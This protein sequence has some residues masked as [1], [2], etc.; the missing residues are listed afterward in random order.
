MTAWFKHRHPQ[1]LPMSTV[2]PALAND[3]SPARFAPPPW[4]DD[5]P[6]WREIDTRLE[7][8]H[9]ARRIDHAVARLDLADL[10]AAYAGTGSSAYRPELLLRVVLYEMRRGHGSP[11]TWYEDA[12]LYDPVR[13]LLRGSTPS[14]TCWYAFRDRLGPVL[15]ALQRQPLAAALAEGLTPATRGALDGTVVAANASRH[16]VL[17]A[18]KLQERLQQLDTVRAADESSASAVLSAVDADAVPLALPSAT[19]EPPPASS[20]VA[21]HEPPPASSSVA[22]AGA[23]TAVAS[24]PAWMAASPAGRRRQ[25]QRLQQAQ[26]A[27]PSGTSAIGP[28]ARVSG[29]PP[30]RSWSARPTPTV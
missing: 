29:R 28:S 1:E 10:Y 6:R 9:L 2:A 26:H 13:W 7:A 25:A 21:A 17:N 18:A 4:D 12:R 14:R 15:P 30:R 23:T 22:A 5:H 20:S 8:D 27:W 19:A 11:A 24:R 16:K 3:C